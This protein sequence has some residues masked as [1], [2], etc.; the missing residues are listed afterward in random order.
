MVRIAASD[1]APAMVA[2][3]QQLKRDR[4]ATLLA[5]LSPDDLAT[6]VRIYESVLTGAGGTR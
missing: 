5:D 4:L 1:T 6:L 2:Q 3:Y